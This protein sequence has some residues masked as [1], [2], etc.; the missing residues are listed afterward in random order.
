[1][2]GHELKHLPVLLL[3]GPVPQLLNLPVF[4]LVHCQE[5]LI[6]LFV[7]LEE[8]GLADQPTGLLTLGVYTY[9]EDVVAF[10]ALQQAL[11]RH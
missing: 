5:L 8:A 6:M 10:V 2:L 7:R 3:E 4:Y 9:V 11:G 1:M